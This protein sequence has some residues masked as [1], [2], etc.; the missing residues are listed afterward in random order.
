[1]AFRENIAELVERE[2][3]NG[4]TQIDPSWSRVP[5][6]SV[7]KVIN[8]YAFKSKQFNASNGTPLIRIRDVLKGYTQT[9]YEGEIPDGYWVERDDILVGMDGDFNT[10]RWPSDKALLN[11]RVCKIEVLDSGVYDSRFLSYLLPAYLK[12]INEHTSATTV[13]HLSSKTLSDL[14]IPNPSIGEQKRIADKLDSVLAKVEAAQARL[15]KIPT[16]LK[17]FRQSVLAAATSGELT[18][19]WRQDNSVAR[20]ENIDGR[21]EIDFEVIEKGELPGNW[22]YVALGNFAKCARGKFSIRPR[23]DPSCFDGE[24]P[25]IQIGDLPREGGSIV[26]HKQTLNEKGFSVSREFESGTV[27]MAIVGATIANT[28]ITTYPVCFPDSL[29]GINSPSDIENVYIDYV[30]RAYKEDIRQASY[31][32]GGQP[33]IKLTTIN[34]LPIPL[35]PKQEIKEIV[36][37]VESLFEHANTVE[38]QYNAASARL[39]KLTQSILAKAFRGELIKNNS[40]EELKVEGITESI[41]PNNKVRAKTNLVTNE[42]VKEKSKPKKKLPAPRVH[43]N[44][45]LVYFETDEPKLWRDT[46]EIRAIEKAEKN[47]ANTDFSLQQLRSVTEYNANDNAFSEFVLRLLKGIPGKLEPLLE[48]TKWDKRTGEYL[49]RLKK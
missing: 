12:L 41:E 38:K 46:M 11:Q 21:Y 17:R 20:T 24:Y 44:N 32:G 2:S 33:N 10:C 49:Y 43:E 48:V 47:M 16:I 29:V 22:Q 42:K 31:A 23:N 8:G 28:G 36:E 40:G 1:M 25:F 3:K 39:D 6:K 15:D 14:P 37:R 45:G 35:A 19:D 18:K 34:P 5:L 9:F 27:V 4:S 26:S 7:A 30:L 13:K